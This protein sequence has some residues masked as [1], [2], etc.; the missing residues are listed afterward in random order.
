MP[1]QPAQVNEYPEVT[2]LTDIPEDKKKVGTPKRV[3]FVAPEENV[4]LGDSTSNSNSLPSSRLKA[5]GIWLN[6]QGLGE[7][8]FELTA[9]AANSGQNTLSSQISMGSKPGTLDPALYF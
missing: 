2:I 1:I 5:P 9:S 3:S 6:R 7:S 4:M 8:D